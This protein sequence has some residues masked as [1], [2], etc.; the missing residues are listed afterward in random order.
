MGKSSIEQ[1]VEAY[2]KHSRGG[3][4]GTRARY[5]DSCMLFSSWLIDT[6]KV[7]NL[8]NLQGKHLAEF[9]AWRK[10][11][12]KDDRTIKNDLAAIRYLHNHIP[13]TR[14]DLPS[15]DELKEQYNIS[16]KNTPEVDKERNRAWVED[17]FNGFIDLAEDLNHYNIAYV[18][19]MS[20]HLGLRISEAVCSQRHQLEKAIRE[21]LYFVESEAKNGRRRVIAINPQ[22]MEVIKEIAKETP[23]AN[24]CFVPDN[25]KA[26]N[27]TKSIQQFI[28]YHRHKVET[29]EGKQLRTHLSNGKVDK[30]NHH[31]LRYLYAQRRIQ[32]ELEKGISRL[33]IKKKISKELG[34]NRKEITKGYASCF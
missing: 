25:K 14:Y 20:R 4:F 5:K 18:I 11:Q 19:K 30:L 13:K 22:A 28:N 9:V 16:F 15:N 17:E 10:L 32:Q 34:H 26:Y 23:R 8:K 7:Q 1:Q 27:V 24:W 6:F 3:S 31:G 2:M 21:G 33:D 29:L 12:G